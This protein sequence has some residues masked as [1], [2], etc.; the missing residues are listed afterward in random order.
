MWSVWKRSVLQTW[1]LFWIDLDNKTPDVLT[2]P[3]HGVMIKNHPTDWFNATDR[4]TVPLIKGDM[5]VNNWDL[6]L[7]FATPCTKRNKNIFNPFPTPLVAAHCRKIKI[8]TTT[9]N[10]S[11]FL[12][13]SRGS[14]NFRKM[15]YLFFFWPWRSDDKFL[16]SS[17]NRFA[18]L[19]YNI[20]R[21]SF[22]CILSYTI[23]KYV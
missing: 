5:T 23:F 13:L 7:H 10:R 2:R 14:R 20:I 18:V 8:F 3:R 9:T 17:R 19:P 12:N 22:S 11:R 15:F 1:R 6:G 16:L 21:G 4:I